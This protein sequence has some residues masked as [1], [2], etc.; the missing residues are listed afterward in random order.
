MAPESDRPFSVSC[1]NGYEGTQ[2]GDALVMTACLYAYSHLSFAD[3]AFAEN[4]AEH[5]HWKREF[6]LAH[7]EAGAILGA[8]D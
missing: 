8:I 2:S 3:R 5:F 7:T 1:D 4:C 6:M